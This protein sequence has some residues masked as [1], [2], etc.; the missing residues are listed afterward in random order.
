MPATQTPP[1]YDPHRVELGPSK[2][3]LFRTFRMPVLT[4]VL[5]VLFL[6]VGFASGT[7]GHNLA[8]ILGCVI[9]LLTA[10]LVA[11]EL[12]DMERSWVAWDSL[13]ITLGRRGKTPLTLLWTDVSQVRVHSC[14]GGRR[15][16]PG[17]SWIYLEVRPLEWRPF[18]RNPDA[19]A[20]Q[21]PYLTDDVLAV[22]ASAG[23]SWCLHLDQT[24]RERKLPAYTGI[25]TTQEADPRAIWRRPTGRDAH[26]Q[27][28]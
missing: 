1:P 7:G 18:D 8:T 13:G 10:M 22:P 26:A 20:Y 14:I 24:L 2:V 6:I 17:R 11:M 3:E 23:D 19:A 27:R 21:Q 12:R 5:A 4:L 15:L 16:T 28:H 25:V 9:L